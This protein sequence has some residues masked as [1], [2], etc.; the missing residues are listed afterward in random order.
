[1][2]K[3]GLASFSSA[4][5]LGW[6]ALAASLAQTRGN[7]LDEP[8]IKISHTARNLQPGEVV[9]I[10]LKSQCALKRVKGRAFGTNVYFY[11][12]SSAEIWQGLLG[13]DLEVT[14]GDH[15]L[16]LQVVQP[17]GNTLRRDY[18]L[19]V[20]D[21]EFPTRRLTVANRFVNPPPKVLERIRRESQK[22]SD[23]F[24]QVTLKKMWAG[25]FLRPVLGAST[26]SFG[27]RSI[28][29]GQPRSPHSGT[30]FQASAG[31]PVKAPGPGMVV[32]ATDLYFSGNTIIIDHGLGLYSYFA[33][34]SQSIVPEGKPVSSGQTIGYVGA[35]GRVTGPHLHWSVRLGAARVDPLSLMHIL[36]TQNTDRP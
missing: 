28:L 17:D 30:D 29:N 3:I 6:G 24:R 10:T 2:Q 23:I 32:L 8:K 1:M 13:I 4:L 12:N 22:V 20:V 14:L 27:K 18:P 15:L 11:S 9:L 19:T 26:S 25:P 5:L 34:L 35:T 31:T 16:E 21:K 33:H 7:V 36:N